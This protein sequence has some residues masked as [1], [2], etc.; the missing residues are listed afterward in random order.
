MGMNVLRASL[1]SDREAPSGWPN[2]AR[3][4]EPLGR[5]LKRRSPWPDRLTSVRYVVGL[6]RNVLSEQLDY[7]TL[8]GQ[9]PI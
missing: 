1:L 5:Y 6:W 7:P 4:K 9:K 8:L 2:Q 3:F